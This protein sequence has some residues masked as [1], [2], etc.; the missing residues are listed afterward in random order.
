MNKNF[1]SISCIKRSICNIKYFYNTFSRYFCI[2]MYSAILHF[3]YMYWKKK[4]IYMYCQFDDEI[5]ILFGLLKKKIG[6]Q[7]QWVERTSLFAPCTKA[8]YHTLSLYDHIL[9][10]HYSQRNWRL[11]VVP[12]VTCTSC[13][14]SQINCRKQ[15]GKRCKKKNAIYLTAVSKYQYK[16]SS[17]SEYISLANKT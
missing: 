9:T 12:M 10:E 4:H 16:F 8:F 17:M 14:N 7:R 11:V 5:Q 1:A 13:C 6:L 15:R 3:K 2:Y